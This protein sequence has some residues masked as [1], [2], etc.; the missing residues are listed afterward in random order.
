MLQ[1]SYYRDFPLKSSLSETRVYQTM[2]EFN[3]VRA[4]LLKVA[5]QISALGSNKSSSGKVL[6]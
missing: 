1:G 5:D 2:A 6:K 3:Q 4:T